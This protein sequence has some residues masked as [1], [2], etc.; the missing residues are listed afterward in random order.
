MV[1]LAHISDLSWSRVKHPSEIL[2][3]GDERELLIS[4]IEKETNR[5]SC[6]IKDLVDSPFKD[7]EKKFKVG[8]IFEKA[9]VVRILDYGIFFE[10]H[11]AVEALAH[12]SEISFT[13]QNVMPKKITKVGNTHDVKIL[14]VEPETNKISVSL[15]IG[16]NPFEKLREQIDKNIKI[17]VS[18]LLL[19][20]IFFTELRVM[21]IY[22]PEFLRL[23]TAV[24]VL[25]KISTSSR[26]F[27]FSMYSK[28]YLYQTS[29]SSVFLS[30]IC[31][32]PVIPGK[33]F[34]LR[35]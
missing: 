7:L 16:E 20:N 3:I 1:L 26:K 34:S 12:K 2:S 17:K 28:S 19:R 14:S 25:N 11:P 32:N 35:I 10:L 9:K 8:E 27:Q 22:F 29:K 23:K 30:F 6:S 13:D 33:T 31:N 24:I 18:L 5:V 21:F 15:K 4:K